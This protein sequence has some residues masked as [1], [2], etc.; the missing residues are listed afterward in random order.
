[1]IGSSSS[2]ERGEGEGG[3]GGGGGTTQEGT[4]IFVILH[5]GV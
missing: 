1:M 2:G 4:A 3:H 5:L